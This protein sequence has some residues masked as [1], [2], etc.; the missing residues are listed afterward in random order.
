MLAALPLAGP[1]ASHVG[2]VV[3]W[4]AER[5]ALPEESVVVLGQ[6]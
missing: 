4:P 2:P 1:L 5:D 6:P 3:R